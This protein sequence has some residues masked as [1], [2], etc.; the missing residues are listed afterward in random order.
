M[1]SSRPYEE[2]NLRPSD[3]ALRCSTANS[4][5][6]SGRALERGIRKSE[7]D[8]SWGLGIFPLSYARDKTKKNL[9]LILSSLQYSTEVLKFGILFQYQ[10]MVWLAFLHKKKTD[11]SISNEMS[12]NWSSCTSTT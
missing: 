6:L 1:Y 11:D 8:F 4:L 5:W 9:S 2:S 3:S 12:L 7:F 10:S